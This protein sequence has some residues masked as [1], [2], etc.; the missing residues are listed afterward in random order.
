[1]S[2]SG[3]SIGGKHPPATKS[4]VGR[5]RG[6]HMSVP[7]MSSV[8]VRGGGGGR[9]EGAKS[10]CSRDESI[11]KR[12]DFSQPRSNFLRLTHLRPPNG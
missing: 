9:E 6:G 1:M 4:T 10:I 11:F 3:I 8:W 12:K 2:L 5:G 7:D